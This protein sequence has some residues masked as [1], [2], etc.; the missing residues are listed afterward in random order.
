[1]TGSSAYRSDEVI[2]VRVKFPQ[3][4]DPAHCSLSCQVHAS[5][6]CLFHLKLKQCLEMPLLN[7]FF[8]FRVFLA[9]SED[10]R[11]RGTIV[12]QGGGKVSL[13]INVHMNLIYTFSSQK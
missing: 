3:M 9:L 12:A 10:P 11:D 6:S 2:Y 1:M 7:L 13:E 4:S 8:N 5:I